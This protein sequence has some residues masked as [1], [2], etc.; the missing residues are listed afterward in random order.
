[1]PE[2]LEHR[3]IRSKSVNSFEDNIEIKE[4]IELLSLDAPKPD[5]LKAILPEHKHN[6]RPPRLFVCQPVSLP[7]FLYCIGQKVTCNGRKH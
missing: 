4:E 6:E 2:T 1:M 5:K 7:S 3:V